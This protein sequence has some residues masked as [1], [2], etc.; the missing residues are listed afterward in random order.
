MTGSGWRLRL[1]CGRGD[2]GVA[3]LGHGFQRAALVGGVAFHRL[4]QIGHEIVPLLELDGDV[5]PRLTGDL[6]Q[7]DEAVVDDDQDNL[8]LAVEYLNERYPVTVAIAGSTPIFDPDNERIR[9]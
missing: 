8:T 7:A 9:S 2:S 5:R 3:R 4:D 1:R 6:T